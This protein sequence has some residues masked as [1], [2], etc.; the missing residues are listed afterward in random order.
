MRFKPF[1]STRNRALVLAKQV[2]YL[3]AALTA[4]HQKQGM[5][6][7]TPAKTLIA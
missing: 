1:E 4:G 2:R 5:V 6:F 3:L 7:Q